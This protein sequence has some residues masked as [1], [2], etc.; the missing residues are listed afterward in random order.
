MVETEGE[1]VLYSVVQTIVRAKLVPVSADHIVHNSGIWKLIWRHWGVRFG[2]VS[3]RLHNDC[4]YFRF[5]LCVLHAVLVS[6]KI[7]LSGEAF[8]TVI[9]Q[10][11]AATM[12][13][14]L[15]AGKR[16]LASIVFLAYGTN[17]T[18]QRSHVANT[19]CFEGAKCGNEAASK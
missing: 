14:C 16:I 17:V 6:F 19:T 5:R 13:R 15:V 12:C 4:W 9:A 10:E 2:Q 1:R 11:T 3:L 18:F 8:P 7:V